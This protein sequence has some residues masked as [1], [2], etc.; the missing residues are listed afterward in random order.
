MPGAW[1]SMETLLRHI[2]CRNLTFESSDKLTNMS[3]RIQDTTHFGVF[4]QLI[5]GSNPAICFGYLIWKGASIEPHWPWAF[6]AGVFI[7][8]NPVKNW[9]HLSKRWYHFVC[10]LLFILELDETIYIYILK[11]SLFI[12]IYFYYIFFYQWAKRTKFVLAVM[13]ESPRR[14]SNS[15]K[16]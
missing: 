4:L 7:M 2:N 9:E 12:C 6:V 14:H 1:R 3:S 10:I 15:S 16:K 8:S 11:V 13:Y 5:Q